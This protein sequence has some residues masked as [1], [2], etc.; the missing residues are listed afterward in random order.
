MPH[1]TNSKVSTPS[2][3]LFSTLS[4]T[5]HV[6][7]CSKW[8]EISRPSSNSFMSVKL[9]LIWKSTLNCTKGK[10]LGS[11]WTLLMALNR[12]KYSQKLRNSSKS[13]F[14]WMT[15]MSILQFVNAL[16][17][18]ANLQYAF[19]ING[20]FK[21]SST[22]TKQLMEIKGCMLRY[23]QVRMRSYSKTVFILC[24]WHFTKNTLKYLT[25]FT[26][27]KRLLC[28]KKRTTWQRCITN[29]T[30]HARSFETGR[31]RLEP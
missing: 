15:N 3:T 2:G 27:T 23:F 9:I 6:S 16:E 20:Q 25:R 8:K 7:Y 29:L 24:Q 18:F 4:R 11:T 26:K 19:S 5:S 31:R 30:N 1:W 12:L 17:T 22:C 14:F 10:K 21:L 13:S 28:N